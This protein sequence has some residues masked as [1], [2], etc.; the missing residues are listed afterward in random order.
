MGSN[1]NQIIVIGR[2]YGSGGRE[3][4]RIIADRLT[5][6]YYDKELLTEAS[7]KSG[8][9]SDIFSQ[10]DE[11]KPGIFRSFFSSFYGAPSYDCS[12]TSM[13]AEKIYEAQSRVIRMIAEKSPCVIVG[14]TADYI[15]RENPNLVSVFIHA[16]KIYRGRRLISRKEAD[17]IDDAIAL[18]E[19]KDK[20][21]SEFYAYFTGRKWGYAPNYDMSVD[22]SLLSADN[23]AELILQFI[24][25]KKI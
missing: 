10:A 22:S 8:I 21:R 19:K 16:D 14:R 20:D 12:Q 24:R 23:T 6:S 15:L 25:T 11:K 7:R 3:I 5:V 18:A 9:D 17:N 13:S 2:Q 4:G 1:N